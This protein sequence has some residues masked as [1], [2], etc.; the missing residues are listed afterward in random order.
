MTQ[1]RQKATTNK[2]TKSYGIWEMCVNFSLIILLTDSFDR[3][4]SSG[5]SLKLV[6]PLFVTMM[7]LMVGSFLYSY[8]KSMIKENE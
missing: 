6:I 1:N 8:M 5:S 4:A 3:W 2:Q 7:F